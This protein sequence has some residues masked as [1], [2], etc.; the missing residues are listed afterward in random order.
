M[1][2]AYLMNS[3]RYMT[4][5]GAND[6]YWSAAQGMGGLNLG[7]AFDGVPRILR[8]QNTNDLFTA[9][10]Q[11]RTFTGRIVRSDKPVRVTL[12]WTDAPGS[13][14]GNAFNNDLDLAVTFQANGYTYK[15]NNFSGP[16][17]IPGGNA[18][19]KNNVESVLLASGISGDITVTVTA[20]NINSDGVPNF[21]TS[22]DQ[23]FALVI[24]NA[25]NTSL[26]L[27]SSA[28][29]TVVAESFFPTNGAV[30]PGE[31]VTV[32]LSLKNNGTATASNL[33]VTLLGTNGIVSPSGTQP[34]G[35]LPATG[36]ATSRPFT[37]TAMGSSGSVINAQV[38]LTD[39]SGDLGKLTVMIPL[40][41]TT[42]QT[43]SFTN[44]TTIPIPDSGKS[45]LYPSPIVV[46][47]VTGTVT[48][49]TATLR[50]YTHSWPDDV[51]VLLVS[52]AGQK[53]MLMSDCGG[54]NARNGVTLTFD[55]SAASSVPDSAA[56]PTGIYKPTNYDTTSDNFPAPAP[57]AP[58][59]TS[60]T[61]LN[62][63]NPNGS[64]SLYVQDD[65]AMDSGSI[66][67][68]WVLSITTSNLTSA[69]GSG[70]AAN[71]S[72]TTDVTSSPITL[73]SNLNLTVTVINHGPD[74]AAYVV[75]TNTLPAGLAFSF[76]NTS[77]GTCSSNNANVNWSLGLLQPGAT[78][79]I[80][81]QTVAT[82][83][84]T[85]TNQAFTTSTTPDPVAANN[86]ALT[87]ISV[88]NPP[89]QLHGST[90]S[91]PLLA[92]I[93]N[94]TV[95]AGSLVVISNIASDAD[96]P[97]NTLTYNL[98]SGGESGASINPASGRF[99][100]QTRDAD[101]D[102]TKNFS[103]SVIDDGTPALSNSRLF[104]I[105]VVSRP[106]ITAISL[107]NDWVNVTWTTIP[108]DTYRLQFTTNLSTPNWIGVTQDVT[109]TISNITHTNPFVP[110]TQH[111]YRVMLVP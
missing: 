47:G 29:A 103:V 107:T 100:W 55:S 106:L 15:G 97:T 68:G 6:N 76:A 57:A 80:N 65:G 3:T 16:V 77:Q 94:R 111:F 87:F 30:D 108:G 67:Q 102:T 90:N 26:P 74:P 58:F 93:A 28:G 54:G 14:T 53:V 5:V 17:S 38:Q 63:T 12:V 13:T 69:T 22:L 70:N 88:T 89:A 35:D 1:T 85:F 21:G 81:I 32:N 43:T 18:D 96:M 23:D 4:G 86:L 61:D 62:G 84:G 10:G 105:S 83:A 66:T 39:D 91:A 44:A 109:A 49:V 8:D 92:A 56:V 45:T 37:F 59:S 104:A 40:G 95:H 79:S 73:G 51:D 75:V 36:I 24:Y 42:I 34:Y 110:G 25:T 98:T 101:T 52:P 64:W 20:A 41:L 9:S 72:V 2:K 46:T 48:S 11:T 60:L 82:I 7:N 71:L 78:A 31:Q 27:L 33:V 99:T 19:A 50:G